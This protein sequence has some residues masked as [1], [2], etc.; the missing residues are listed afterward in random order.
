MLVHFKY[1]LY[2]QILCVQVYVSFCLLAG[3][4]KLW[5]SLQCCPQT[6]QKDG[7]YLKTLLSSLYIHCAFTVL[8]GVDKMFIMLQL[9][10]LQIQ[11]LSAI[12]HNRSLLQ[13]IHVMIF[14][15]SPSIFNLASDS[16]QKKNWC[17]SSISA[18]YTMT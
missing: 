3:I 14:D 10:K 1:N 6:L 13:T 15:S 18:A 16:Q 11:V 4:N 5:C 7:Y 2:L 9:E 17:F 8:T 12:E